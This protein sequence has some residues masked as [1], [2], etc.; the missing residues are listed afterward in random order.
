MDETPPNEDQLIV[1]LKERQEQHN[2]APSTVKP[3]ICIL[4]SQFLKNYGID[5]M[6]YSKLNMY[7]KNLTRGY[8]TTKADVFTTEQWVK[9]MNEA[10]D[11]P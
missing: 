1:Y 3:L 7:M 2:Y 8:E 6:K 9:F 11:T 5:T 4:K 10:D